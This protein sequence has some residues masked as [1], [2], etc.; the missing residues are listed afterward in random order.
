MSAWSCY[1]DVKPTPKG[2]PRL[3]PRG[4]TYTPAATR[5]AEQAI[6]WMIH[7]D[8]M[9]KGYWELPIFPEGAL[10]VSLWFSIPTKK[11]ALWGKP[12]WK[13][14]DGDNLA[15]L[16]LDAPSCMLGFKNLLWSDDAQIAELH[17]RK[18]YEAKGRILITVEPC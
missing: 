8:L 15:K 4:R 11:K 16:V 10:R 5:K 17:V 18:C 9:E 14:P 3:S 6:Y 13:R 12:H 7:E 1:L 2:R